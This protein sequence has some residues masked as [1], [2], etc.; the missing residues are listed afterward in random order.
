M[1]R[2]TNKLNLPPA[3]VKA[4]QSGRAKYSK[5]ASDYS[6]TELQQPP[7][8]RALK[9]RHEDE[10]EEDASDMIYALQGQIGHALLEMAAEGDNDIVEK[11]FFYTLSVKLDGKEKPITVSGQADL[12][13]NPGTQ[14]FGIYDW[15]FSSI[16]QFKDGIKT[17][18]IAQLN[19]LEYLITKSEEKEGRT[20]E[21][22]GLYSVPIYRDW[23][24]TR[25]GMV[26]NYPLSPIEVIEAERWGLKGTE[27][28][29]KEMVRKHEAAAKLP[30]DKLPLCSPEDR[31][32]RSEAFAV[33]AE[34]GKKASAMFFPD[35]DTNAKQLAEARA[36]ELTEGSRKEKTDRQ[37]KIKTL[38]DPTKTYVVQHRPAQNIRCESYCQVAPFCD[39]YKKNVEP[40]LKK[41]QTTIDN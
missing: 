8:I 24:K 13:R 20:I 14:K 2:I 17:D 11:R 10:I 36:G 3:V 9:K 19:I 4:I 6:T 32:A 38:G 16:F 7:R 23:S 25:I 35:S 39:F 41:E 37:T 40:F 30:D 34:G 28:Y 1:S 33:I 27:M 26:S 29:I 15:K 5:G 22:E 21:I 18:Y 12:I 31:W